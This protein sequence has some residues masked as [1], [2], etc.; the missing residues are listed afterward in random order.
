MMHQKIG[1]CVRRRARKHRNRNGNKRIIN[2]LGAIDTGDARV[3]FEHHHDSVKSAPNP[4]YR[5][6]QMKARVFSINM[7]VSRYWRHLIK[8]KC[9]SLSTQTLTKV[10]FGGV[11][12]GRLDPPILHTIRVP[13]STTQQ[14]PN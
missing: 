4:I 9:H 10:M 5:F 7:Y 3:T 1:F 6:V 14:L 2:F 8:G 12:F 11:R 13:H